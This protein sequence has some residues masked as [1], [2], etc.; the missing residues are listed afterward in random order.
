MNIISQIEKT[1]VDKEFTHTTYI[2]GFTVYV[3]IPGAASWGRF[4]EEAADLLCDSGYGSLVTPLPRN[5]I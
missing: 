4:V 2:F 3:I 1:T 5:G